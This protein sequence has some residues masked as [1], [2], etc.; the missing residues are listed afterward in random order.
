MICSSYR[1]NKALW[2]DLPSQTI[3]LAKSG[4]KIVFMKEKLDDGRI[5]FVR[6]PWEAVEIKE[7]KTLK[8]KAE[9]GGSS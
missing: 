8:L 7:N 2:E 6:D 9:E 5:G 3:V 1:A 4:R